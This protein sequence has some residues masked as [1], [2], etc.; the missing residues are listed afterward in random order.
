MK[1]LIDRVENG[2]FRW[3]GRTLLFVR[4]QEGRDLLQRL[5]TNDLGQLDTGPVQTV[6][7]TEK[8]KIVDILTVLK[9]SDEML[10][11]A[12]ISRAPD[13]T[14]S[15]LNKFIIMED[16]AVTSAADAFEHILLPGDQGNLSTP[17]IP[18][19]RDSWGQ[20]FLIRRGN[21]IPTPLAG[22]P[23]VG[24]TDLETYR[25]L[26]GIPEWGSELSESYNPLEAGLEKLVSWT[27]G[28]YVGQEVIARLDT[29]KKVQNKLIIFELS[30]TCPV[31]ARI[32][33]GDR[34]VGTLT[35]ATGVD[36]GRACGLGYLRSGPES[37]EGLQ[38][39][40]GNE[41]IPLKSREGNEGSIRIDGR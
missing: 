22:K 32:V 39:R 17:G 10:L 1:E 21:D 41:W 29:Y 18:G 31:P 34:E 4:G 27:K 40:D 7:T 20:H 5:S 15:W 8:G 28:C 13:A 30:K 33:R 2:K 3:E 12:G 9:L 11:L 36:G 16:I 6:L 37:M 35:S 25:I 38:V 23:A 26:K 19:F 24:S 14:E